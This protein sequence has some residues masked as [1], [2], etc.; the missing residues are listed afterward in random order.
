M[1]IKA[2]YVL[3]AI[4][5]TETQLTIRLFREEIEVYKSVIINDDVIHRVFT[6]F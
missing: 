1:L 6:L 4:N 3:W 2:S 5:F